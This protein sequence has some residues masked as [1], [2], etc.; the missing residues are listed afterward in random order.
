MLIDAGGYSIDIT[1][2][3]IID[4]NG[5]IKQL[6]ETKQFNLGV[7]DISNRIIKILKEMF[8]E[9]ILNKIKNDYPGEWIKILNEI[10]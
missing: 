5:S 2:Y 7:L 9:K 6:L 8:G 4:D 10:N 3:K 1:I